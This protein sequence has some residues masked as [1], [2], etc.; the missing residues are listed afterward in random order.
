MI[1]NG[2][3]VLG[4]FLIAASGVGLFA[5]YQQTNA[6]P[7]TRFVVAT[8]A[9][10]PGEIIERDDL[11]LAPAEVPP[12]MADSLSEDWRSMVGRVT[13][14]A[15]GRNQFLD[16]ASLAEPGTTDGP[17]R[18]VALELTRAGALD[19]GLQRGSIVDVLA[20]IDG[21]TEATVVADRARV[22]AVNDSA[23]GDLGQLGSLV[24]TLELPTEQA[25]ADVVGANAAGTITLAAPAPATVAD[26]PE[27]S[28]DGG[29]T[30]D[31]GDVRPEPAE[32]TDG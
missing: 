20:A 26:D 30:D 22:V 25:L 1:P 10:A 29:S 7:E 13:T 17:A 5:A 16:P 15:V 14:A 9:L 11:G 12:E 3:A 28:V 6:A 27:R 4:G 32:G 2:R 19:G 23:S 24:V 31:Q 21:E 18:R 8:R